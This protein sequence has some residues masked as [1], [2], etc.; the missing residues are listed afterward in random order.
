MIHLYVRRNKMKKLE[1]IFILALFA[2]TANLTAVQPL[3]VPS[4]TEPQGI[5]VIVEDLPGK[6]SEE[7]NLSKSAIQSK[8]EQTL[9]RFSLEPSNSEHF[10]KG[11][12][13]VNVNLV[14]PSYAV[15][16]EYKRRFWL[17]EQVTNVT[18]TVW[19][20]GSLGIDPNYSRHTVLNKLVE[21][22]EQFS[23][24]YIK[25]NRR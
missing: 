21:F 7:W 11:Y 1:T 20:K 6:G 8:V 2:L 5:E 4:W 14:G 10:D 23:T 22:T 3:K 9:M 17:K 24:E 12:L 16:I 19:D 25:Q 13:Y 15:S 18:A